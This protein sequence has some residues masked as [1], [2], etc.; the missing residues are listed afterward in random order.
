MSQDHQSDWSREITETSNA[1]DLDPGVFTW[2]DPRRIALSL[3]HS[4]DS[5]ERRK[6][7]PF[8]SAMSM[9]NFYI[10]RAGKRLPV[11][12]RKVLE[13]TKDELRLLYG[14]SRHDG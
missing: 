12:Q 6:A 8:A 5:S 1:L 4:A 3:K 7:E 2:N 11:A 9:L 10:N 13:R 14:K